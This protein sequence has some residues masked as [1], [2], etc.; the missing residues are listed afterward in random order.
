LQTLFTRTITIYIIIVVLL[1]IDAFINSINNIYKESFEISKSKPI[2]GYLQTVK[3]ILFSL[4]GIIIISTAIGK[5]AIFLLSGLGALTAVLMLVFKDPILGFVGSIQLSA[6]DMVRPDDWISM[7]DYGADGTVIDMNLTTV[8]VRN[9]DQTISTIPT[10][11]LVA[12]SF[13]NWRG[14]EEG[15]GRRIMRSI[16][17]NVKSIKF[18]S[19]ELLAKLKNNRLIAD[20][21]K[22]KEDELKKHNEK[23]DINPKVKI[24]TRRQTNIGVFRNYLVNYLESH[25]QINR[26]MTLIVRQ[27]E[28]TETGLPLQIYCF[29]SEKAWVQYENIQSNI[30][31]HILTVMPE[32]ELE[33]FQNPSGDDFKNLTIRN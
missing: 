8:K 19:P 25:P 17:I 20:Y 23:Y 28:T 9:W 13:Q 6:N 7:P 18:C 5:S 31:D 14:M 22:E 12:N 11:A 1:A 24:N 10:Y 27:L 2:K 33:L 29:T 32:F 26:D 30:F 4:G 3:I 16:K 15:G 21:L